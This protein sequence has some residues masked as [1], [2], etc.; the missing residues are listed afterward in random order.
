MKNHDPENGDRPII[1]GFAEIS[2]YKAIPDLLGEYRGNPFIEALPEIWDWSGDEPQVMD[3]LTHYFKI[4][5]QVREA[6]LPIR[7]HKL[8]TFKHQFFQVSNRVRDL[9]ISVSIILRQGYIARNPMNARYRR[10][11]HDRLLRVNMERRQIVSVGN[12]GLTLLGAPG[13]GKTRSLER[14]LL[15]YPQIIYHE[16]YPGDPGFRHTQVVWLYLTCSHDKSTRGLC[17]MFFK[18]VDQVLGTEYY[19][20]YRR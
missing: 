17:L 3:E 10:D 11:L 2:K 16:N 5:K 12:L 14:I 8:G 4:D 7:Q 9:E 18:E 20:E 19:D 6:P 13:Q 1:R 15:L